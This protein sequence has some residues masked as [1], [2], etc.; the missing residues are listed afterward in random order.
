MGTITKTLRGVGVGTATITATDGTNTAEYSPVCYE[1]TGFNYYLNGTL[2]EGA[3]TTYWLNHDIDLSENNMII[4]CVPI[5]NPAGITMP[6]SAYT[7]IQINSTVRTEEVGWPAGLDV[8]VSVMGIGPHGGLNVVIQKVGNLDTVKMGEISIGLTADVMGVSETLMSNTDFRYMKYTT[9][10][11]V[12]I[13]GFN[14]I[15]LRCGTELTGS[16]QVTYSPADASLDSFYWYK[17]WQENKFNL[18][19]D[20]SVPGVLTFNVERIDMNAFE[21]H[22]NL[23]ASGTPRGSMLEVYFS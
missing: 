16:S 3:V 7:N 21:G 4:E 1:I 15:P 2:L 6:I 9:V 10:P 17:S 13:S 8:S 14:P 5:T 20:T 22:I 18:T 12:T 23:I 11:H 19:V